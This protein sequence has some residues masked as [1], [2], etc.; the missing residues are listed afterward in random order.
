MTLKNVL[1]LFK[2][3]SILVT[4]CFLAFCSCFLTPPDL[5][6]IHYID[7]RT[8]ILLFSLMA[9]MAGMQDIGIFYW[10][11]SKLLKTV[12]TQKA[13]VCIL[14]FLCFFSS[15]LIT[16]DVAL[17]TFVPLCIMILKLIK[18]EC[19]ICITIVLQTIAANLGSMLTPVGNPQN[20]YLYI[21]SGFSLKQFIQITFPYVMLAASIILI[22][23]HIFYKEKTPF[24]QIHIKQNHLNSKRVCYYSILFVLCL[25]TVIR[26]FPITM[27]LF[28]INIGIFLDNKTLFKKVDYSLLFTFLAFFILIGNIGRF[29][30]FHAFIAKI[31]QG[32]ETLTAII[33]SQFISNVPAALL[34][35]GFTL[36][37]KELIIGVNIGGLGT[38]IASM[39][40]LI[41]YKQ[42]ISEYPYDKRKYVFAFTWWNLLFLILLVFG[43][44]I[45]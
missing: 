39:A 6:Y 43:S 36:Q 22:V 16:N 31:I 23:V 11:S 19:L 30:P 20:L 33:I 38:L 7:F 18:K 28:T 29:P 42:M 2:K 32:Q 24:E 40:S 44:K 10:I 15:M 13:L 17:I 12:H 8:L 25:F 21:A 35:S 5:Q 14:I 3:E 45:F 9:V 41:S 27:L 4:A 1:L 26:I 34:L 37:W